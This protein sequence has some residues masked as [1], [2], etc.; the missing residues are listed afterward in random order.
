MSWY[1]YYAIL[2][3]TLYMAQEVSCQKTSLVAG[4]DS[5]TMHDIPKKLPDSFG[6]DTT[7]LRTCRSGWRVWSVCQGQKDL[8]VWW[9]WQIAS[10]G[11]NEKPFRF[12]FIELLAASQFSFLMFMHLDSFAI[13]IEF[14][15]SRICCGGTLKRTVWLDLIGYQHLWCLSKPCEKSVNYT[16]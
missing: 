15:N 1:H 14:K 3:H 7:G 16:S 4:L 10:C 9:Q 2:S 13:F 8:G 12:L 5:S 6:S 11:T